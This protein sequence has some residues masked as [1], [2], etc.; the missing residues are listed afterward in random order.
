MSLQNEEMREGYRQL[1]AWLKA[2]QQATHYAQ[3]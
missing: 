2:H 3:Q 1:N